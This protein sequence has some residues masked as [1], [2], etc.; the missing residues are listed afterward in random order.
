MTGLIT[1]LKFIFYFF[2]GMSLV[3]FLVNAF[4]GWE[5]KGQYKKLVCVTLIL[6]LASFGVLYIIA[7]V[8]EIVSP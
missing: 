2:I 1:V 8:I 5:K 6:S 7:K 4:T 3:G